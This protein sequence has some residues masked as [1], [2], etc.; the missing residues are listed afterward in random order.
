M[1][2]PGYESKSVI[3]ERGGHIHGTSEAA[4]TRTESHVEALV[5]GVREKNRE[6]VSTALAKGADTNGSIEQNITPLGAAVD[7]LVIPDIEIL[8]L[9][10]EAGA[11]PN[12]QWGNCGTTP[13]YSLVQSSCWGKKSPKELSSYS[14]DIR[15]MIRHGADPNRKQGAFGHSPLSYAVMRGADLS[16]IKILVEEGHGVVTDKMIEGSKNEAVKEYLQGYKKG[17]SK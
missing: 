4:A 10:L 13:F 14:E 15:L 7:G 1:K 12:R 8:R 3:A 5:R 11:D 6:L 17:E 9:L 16:L 2:Q